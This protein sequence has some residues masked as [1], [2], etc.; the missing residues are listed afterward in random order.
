LEIDEAYKKG[1]ISFIRKNIDKLVLAGNQDPSKLV[2]YKAMIKNESS[3]VRDLEKL[4]K[5][6][7][8]Y[9][10]Q[11]STLELGKIHFLERRFILSRQKLLSI[12]QSE[13]LEE[14]R[15][16]LSF[17]EYNLKEYKQSIYFAQNYLSTATN[18]DKIEQIYI[19]IS[20]AYMDLGQ[21]ELAKKLLLSVDRANLFRSSQSVSWYKLGVC[22]DKLGEQ[23]ARTML[24]SE[25]RRKY[26]YSKYSKAVQNL[27]KDSSYYKNIS[28]GSNQNSYLQVGA[29]SNI[30][31]ANE[32]RKKLI[33]KKFKVKID[34]LTKDGKQIHKVL[35][36]PL[37]TSQEI[38]KT[39][40]ELLGS[41]IKSFLVKSIA[42][43][44]TKAKKQFYL[45]TGVYKDPQLLR[46]RIE[47]LANINIK[48]K[49]FRRK[50]G[51]NL[52]YYGVIG[53][54]KSREDAE[55]QKE[56]LLNNHEINSSLFVK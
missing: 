9:Y 4:S 12:K 34:E 48:A 43:I 26:P 15:Y 51:E 8:G 7:S 23:V 33:A 10:G 55:K 22:Y 38:V 53:P 13:L 24:Y 1:D 16:W 46:K 28:S 35:V 5:N 11:I 30:S 3:F 37:S 2:F 27:I 19:L 52:F 54:F 45:Q 41:N 29:F 40:D 25:L 18:N 6:D 21:Y 56:N 44:P 47:K 14:K 17:V 49:S 39:R 32:L 50:V 31:N 20:S 42:S 36:G